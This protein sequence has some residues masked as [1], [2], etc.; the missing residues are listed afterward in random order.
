M[1]RFLVEKYTIRRFPVRPFVVIVVIAIVLI[2]IWYKVPQVRQRVMGTIANTQEVSRLKN[3]VRCVNKQD[4]SVTIV[5]YKQG[6]EIGRVA[7]TVLFVIPEIGEEADVKFEAANVILFKCI[8]QYQW[9]G[10]V[11]LVFLDTT[12]VQTLDD[13]GHHIAATP[14]AILDMSGEALESLDFS[15]PV[16]EQIYTDISNGLAFFIPYWGGGDFPLNIDGKLA[17]QRYIDALEADG[18]Q[19]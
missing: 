5:G 13:M 10:G 8:A 4:P 1:K 7:F 18:K 3:V 14:I 6:T 9:I 12:P 2:G 16:L 19:V 15:I 11:V 17:A